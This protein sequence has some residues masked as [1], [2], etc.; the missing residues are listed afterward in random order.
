[1]D[2]VI[3][4]ITVAPRVSRYKEQSDLGRSYTLLLRFFGDCFFVPV[5]SARSLKIT[6][7]GL[8]D[9]KAGSIIEF[10]IPIYLCRAAMR[11]ATKGKRRERKERDRTLGYPMGLQS[12]AMQLLATTQTETNE[13]EHPMSL[14]LNGRRKSAE[15]YT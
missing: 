13:H 6:K 12:F 8:P 15:H 2:L 5:L 14:L 9:R 10:P 11:L 4:S 7:V 1:M 3:D